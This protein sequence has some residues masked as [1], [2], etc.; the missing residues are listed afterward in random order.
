MASIS[1]A[2]R[3][4]YARQAL[5]DWEVY[6]W[7]LLAAHL[8]ACHRLHALQMALEKAAKAHV[9]P[10]LVPGVSIDPMKH[11]VVA[12][13]LP[14]YYRHRLAEGRGPTQ[15]VEAAVRRVRRFCEEIDLLAPANQA[16]GARP[17]NCEYP[18]EHPSAVGGRDC[19]APVDHVFPIEV[20]LQERKLVEFL[21][22]IRRHTQDLAA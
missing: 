3:R 16:G 4:A 12:K 10:D 11:G 13:V 18:W 8:P 1:A 6:D 7:L 14:V 22:I 15:N 19:R 9:A 20:M 2:L 17:D 21:R 5:S